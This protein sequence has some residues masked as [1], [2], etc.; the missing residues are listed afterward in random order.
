[1]NNIRSSIEEESLV[2]GS[3][4]DNVSEDFVGTQFDKFRPITGEELIKY[5]DKISS[6]FCCLDPIPTFLLKKCSKQLAPILLHIVNS[7]LSKA[8]FP[9][10]MKRA[11]IKPTI[12]KTNADADCLKNYRPV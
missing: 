6:K 8:L 12:K 5:A 1:M 9:S 4:S 7:S 11:V 10:E 2:G 3:E